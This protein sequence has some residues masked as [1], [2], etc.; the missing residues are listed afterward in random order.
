M[1]YEFRW[2]KIRYDL[3]KLPMME[4]QA[5]MPAKCLRAIMGGNRQGQYL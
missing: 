2:Q 4:A 5:G 1:F 3:K